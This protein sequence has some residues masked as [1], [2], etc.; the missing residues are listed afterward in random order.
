MSSSVRGI[1]SLDLN[2]SDAHWPFYETT[3]YMSMI[4][5]SYNTVSSLIVDAFMLYPIEANAVGNKI[6]HVVSVQVCKNTST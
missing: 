6:G 5:N 4:Y 2:T 3:V 1:Q